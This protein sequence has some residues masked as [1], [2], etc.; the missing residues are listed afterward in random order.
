MKIGFLQNI[1]FIR[2]LKKKKSFVKFLAS[3]SLKTKLLG[4]ILYSGG[5]HRIYEYGKRHVVKVVK[6]DFIHIL[7]GIHS[8]KEIKKEDA[9]LRKYFPNQ[10][11]KTKIFE[12]EI[13]PY[14][15]IY[16]SRIHKIKHANTRLIKKHKASF[17]DLLEQNT[18]M[19]QE[20]GYFLDLFG[21]HGLIQTFISSLKERKIRIFLHNIAF[22]K[23]QFLIIDTNL[24]RINEKSERNIIKRIRFQTLKYIYEKLIELSL[25]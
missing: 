6:S 4:N 21:R 2:D 18:K 12:S 7:F 14:Y 10:Y 3:T 13:Y 20:T 19:E 1:L 25:K 22:H 24:L 23:N 9:L 5:Q 15:V 17:F 11:L 8:I 16:Q